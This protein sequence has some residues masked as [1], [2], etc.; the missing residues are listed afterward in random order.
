MERVRFNLLQNFR[1]LLIWILIALG[2]PVHAFEVDVE[3][4]W[5]TVNVDTRLIEYFAT[6]LHPCYESERAVL[7]CIRMVNGIGRFTQPEQGLLPTT[8]AGLQFG[9]VP[10]PRLEGRPKDRV[11]AYR[12]RA[13]ELRRAAAATYQSGSR[14]PSARLDFVALAKT[15]LARRI[16][17]Y[18]APFVMAAGINELMSVHDAHSELKVTAYDELATASADEDLNGI[19]VR[20][21]FSRIDEHPHIIDVIE[22]APA[23]RSGL[24]RG[25]TITSIN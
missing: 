22:E 16:S 25:D 9:P 11:E 10:R 21:A 1:H 14:A 23:A 4:G 6:E 8:S 7:G 12:R 3:R 5:S 19:G 13:E 24:R 18:S 17:P 20:V 2:V 15:L